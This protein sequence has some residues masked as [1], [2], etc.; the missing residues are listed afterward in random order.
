M[1]KVQVYIS[2]ITV[3]KTVEKHFHFKVKQKTFKAKQALFNIGCII[4]S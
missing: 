3:T 1:Y 4:L 2:I